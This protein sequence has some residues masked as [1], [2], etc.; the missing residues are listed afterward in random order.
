MPWFRINQFDANGGSAG[1]LPAQ[2]VPPGVFT[3]ARNVRFLDGAIEKAGGMAEQYGTPPIAPYYLLS[4]Q[5]NDGVKRLFLA[6]QAAIHY[7]LSGVYSDA[8]RQP[9]GVLTPYSAGVGNVWTGGVLHGIPFLNNGTDA[10]Q[11]FDKSTGLFKDLSNWPIGYTA[12]ALRP[13][14]NYLVAMNHSDGTLGFPH[15]VLWSHPAN[16]GSVPGTW[17]VTD[18]TKDA[19]DTPLSD[20]P[21]HIIDGLAMGDN[22]VV[23]KE[24]ATYLMQFVGAPFIFK[25]RPVLRESGIL[26][27]NCMVEVLGRHI[28]LTTDDVIA[29]DGTQAESIINKKWRRDLF[30]NISV[31]D[32]HKSYLAVFPAEREV[33]ICISTTSGYPP[34]LAYVWNWKT[35]TWA[36]RDL[37]FAQSLI[38][39]FTPDPTDASWDS[40]SGNWDGDGEG[41][42]AFTLRGKV[43]VV[44]NTIGQ[45]L[46]TLN[47]GETIGADAMQTLLEHQSFDFAD[48]KNVDIADAVKHISKLRPKIL[49]ANGTQLE[50]QIGVQMNLNDPIDWGEVQ[51]YVVGTNAELCMGRN[52]RYI[53]WRITGSGNATWRLEAMD[54]LV[55]GGG[56]Y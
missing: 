35:N 38:S 48:P 16:P 39:A 32:Y 33:W 24:D 53:S 5:E 12:Q 6:G 36:K 37:P 30:S 21:G 56:R 40:D 50:F 29:F 19:G 28:V 26:G 42:S 44:A 52:G 10:P 18:P 11:E 22:F 41:W 45:K 15:N 55:Q 2:A 49:A 7:Y 31:S 4:S 23:Y 9:L 47:V 27:R 25:F 8:T 51:P 14:K 17:D 13:F 34:N 54:F 20:T 43:G 46:Y 1:D 3:D